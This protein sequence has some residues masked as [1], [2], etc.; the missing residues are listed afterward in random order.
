M[1]DTKPW[2]DVSQGSHASAVAV[3]KAV[4]K[5]I[6]EICD[7]LDPAK[8]RMSQCAGVFEIWIHY[9]RAF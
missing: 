2:L 3:M 7:G 6:N 8:L 4:E 9:I 5:A 1:N